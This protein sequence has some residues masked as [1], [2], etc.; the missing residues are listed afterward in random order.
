MAYLRKNRDKS[1]KLW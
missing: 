1:K